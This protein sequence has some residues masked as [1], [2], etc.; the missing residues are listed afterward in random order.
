MWAAKRRSPKTESQ[1]W[2]LFGAQGYQAKS[3]KWAEKKWPFLE[4]GP[5]KRE[6][7]RVSKNEVTIG[8][9]K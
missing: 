5:R 6:V 7:K 8:C 1:D 2:P 4:Q 9:A 3:E